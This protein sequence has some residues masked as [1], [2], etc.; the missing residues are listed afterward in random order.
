MNINIL[1]ISIPVFHINMHILYKLLKLCFEN[2]ERIDCIYSKKFERI[3]IGL[4]KY[5]KTKYVKTVEF[6]MNNINRFI[7]EKEING[8]NTYFYMLNLKIMRKDK[9]AF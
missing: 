8:N 4:V 7:F 9:F 3:F 6:Q 5:T 2:I 1:I